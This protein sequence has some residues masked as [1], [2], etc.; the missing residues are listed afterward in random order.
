V[1][2]HPAAALQSCVWPDLWSP[3]GVEE[4]GAFTLRFIQEPGRP[5]RF[6]G[7]RPVGDTGIISPGSERGARP[8]SGSESKT[9]SMVPP[10][11]GN[12][13]RREE[14]WGFG[15]SHSTA[16]AGEPTQGTLWR[17]GDAGT[18]NRRRERWPR[19]RA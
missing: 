9:R 16:E 2:N 1:L 11:E 19:H 3:A 6:H 8:G 18:R 17:E 7:S 13:A 15:A 4:Q 10:S 5:E 12:E 14:R